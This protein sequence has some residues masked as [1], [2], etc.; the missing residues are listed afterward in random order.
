[1]ARALG[2]GQRRFPRISEEHA[3][4][5]RKLAPGL[6]EG[7]YKTSGLG[8]GGCEFFAGTPF[9]VGSRLDVMIS[10]ERRVIRAEGRVVYL[11]LIHI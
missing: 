6:P 5:V 1:M 2:Q 4:L 3:V 7:L 10:L 11:S 8:L 9:G